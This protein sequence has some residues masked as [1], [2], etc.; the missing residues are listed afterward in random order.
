MRNIKH[1]HFN[2]IDF[3]EGEES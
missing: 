2:A 1:K 3:I